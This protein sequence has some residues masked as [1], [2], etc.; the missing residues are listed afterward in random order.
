MYVL[1]CYRYATCIYIP[2]WMLTNQSHTHAYP[3]M[4]MHFI[5]FFVHVLVW[6]LHHS[7]EHFAGLY[8][9]SFS[10]NNQ[11]WITALLISRLHCIISQICRIWQ[12]SQVQA[13]KLWYRFPRF[14]KSC[15]KFETFNY[16]GGSGNKMFC[17]FVY[18]IGVQFPPGVTSLSDENLLTF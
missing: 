18:Q 2:I 10:D 9:R 15:M 3:C 5:A 16:F 7:V 13:W 4:A 14:L 6:Y 11:H 8:H 17:N 12:W 1:E